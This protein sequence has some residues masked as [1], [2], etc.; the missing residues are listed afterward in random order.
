[1]SSRFR[2]ARRGGAFTLIELLVVIAIIAILIGLLLPA[3]QKVREAAARA[4]CQNNV[5][6]LALGVHNYESANQFVPPAWGP[7]SGGGTF[8]TNTS[9]TGAAYGTL[10]FFLLSQIEQNT[11]FTLAGGGNSNNNGAHTKIVKTFLC[12]SETTAASFIGRYGYASTNYACNMLVF[13][14][15]AKKSLVNSMPDGTANTVIWGER[16]RDCLPSWGGQTDSQWALHPAYVGHGW[17]TPA[18]GWR[19]ANIG[20]DPGWY[21]TITGQG[22][23]RGY[24]F[25]VAPQPSACDWY[26]LQ[27]AHSGVMIAG[28][29][30]GS[31]RAVSNAVSLTT[32]N[33]ACKPND[34]NVLG[35]DW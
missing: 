7:D 6:Q 34:G 3:V 31:V 23:N 17:D 9:Y 29:G 1:M 30:D 26:V 33:Y 10:H 16:F 11:I 18:F 24:A 12:P 14:P 21:D 15:R 27:G 5:K 20:F 2:S 28:L 32:W 4:T 22:V 13:D 8:G 19:N 35:T 25:Q